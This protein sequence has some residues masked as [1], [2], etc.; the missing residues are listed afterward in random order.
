[1]FM[2]P[3]M[4]TPALPPLCTDAAISSR[5]CCNMECITSLGHYYSGCKSALL[6]QCITS[7]VH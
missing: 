7:L 3:F 6:H 2:L 5:C 1:M 4:Y